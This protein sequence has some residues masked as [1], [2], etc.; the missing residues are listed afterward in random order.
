MD[1]AVLTLVNRAFTPT[2]AQLGFQQGIDVHQALLTADFNAH[3]GLSHMAVLYLEKAHD[4]VN[5]RK[6]LHLTSKWLTPIVLNILRSLLGQLYIWC[7][8]DPTKLIVQRT[9]GVPQGA[10]SSPVLF[11]M[12]IDALSEE[13]RTMTT[14]GQG[15]G[16]AVMVAEDLLLQATSLSVLQQ[17]LN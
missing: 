14:G 5:Q 10:P 15:E 3:R 6:L 12:C 13:V 4:R 2:K 8:G 9:S 17:L 1:A 16:A 7:K 11:N